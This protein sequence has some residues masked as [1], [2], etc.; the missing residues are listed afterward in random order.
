MQTRPDEVSRVSLVLAS[1]VLIAL[2]ALQPARLAAQTCM[3]TAPFSAGGGRIGLLL[4]SNRDANSIGAT[5]SAGMARGLFVNTSISRLSID[6]ASDAAPA[7]AATAGYGFDIETPPDHL[8]VQLCPFAGVEYV[9]GPQVNL[10]VGIP[11][12]H[13]TSRAYK[14]GLALGEMLQKHAR[15]AIVPNASFY[16]VAETAATRQDFERR[17]IS[18]Y[19]GVFEAGMGIVIDRVLTLQAGLA[20]PLWLDRAANTFGLGVGF[21]FGGGGPER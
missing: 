9:D 4:A 12:I 15:Y 19:Y 8:G 13:V 10:G 11:T 14:V 17:E 5:L 1:C 18:E 16:Y 3:G 20:L 6:V 2:V 21:N 7:F